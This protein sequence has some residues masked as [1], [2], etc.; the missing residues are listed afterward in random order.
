MQNALCFV[1]VFALTSATAQEQKR[2]TPPTMDDLVGAWIGFEDGGS[3]FIRA[4]LH[5]D[6]SGY[7]AMVSPSNLITHDYGVQ[8]Y[9]ALRELQ[10]PRS[11]G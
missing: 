4:E 8:I 1:F 6:G 11:T 7:L 2:A 9:D 10:I 3:E 5:R